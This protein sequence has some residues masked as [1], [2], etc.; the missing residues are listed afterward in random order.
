MKTAPHS[1]AQ[2]LRSHD[3]I[4]HCLAVV[5]YIDFVKIAI[6]LAAPMSI[7][8][9]R[10]KLPE[11]WKCSP[12]VEVN[13]AH[14]DIPGAMGPS[15]SGTNFY[16]LTVHEPHLYPFD[17]S[18][19]PAY[20]D[21]ING[22]LSREHS[23]VE[24]GCDFTPQKDADHFDAYK[25]KLSGFLIRM[26]SH[27]K[28]QQALGLTSTRVFCPYPIGA[29]VQNQK[30]TAWVGHHDKGYTETITDKA[31]K[32]PPDSCTSTGTH[33]RYAMH[34]SGRGGTFYMGRSSGAIKAK[35]YGVPTRIWQ[36]STE[37]RAYFKAHD[38]NAALPAD[39]HRFRAEFVAPCISPSSPA[40]DLDPI[41]VLSGASDTACV[42]AKFF[43][44][45]L[46]SHPL[47][48]AI[49]QCRVISPVSD[50]PE[51]VLLIDGK[52]TTKSKLSNQMKRRG[53]AGMAPARIGADTGWNQFITGKFTG[54]AA[55]MKCA[56]F[57]LESAAKPTTTAPTPCPAVKTD[58]ATIASEGKVQK[59]GGEIAPESVGLAASVA[60][61]APSG[62][63]GVLITAPTTS[64][65]GDGR[66]TLSEED[67]LRMLV[68]ME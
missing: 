47:L 41:K 28:H 40:F 35:V 68:E 26:V 44:L 59:V 20:L 9:V 6:K 34:P 12:H 17:V 54:M 48:S 18:L 3:F 15:S 55:K 14:K 11:C 21:A 49:K 66:C 27:F 46:P 52:E 5:P 63:S 1:A 45:V 24:F 57:T 37:L 65:Q 50:K 22:Q 58:Q 56:T 30:R 16:T 36:P 53:K 51:A 2:G 62:T 7:N 60:S 67:L 38:K 13:S 19:L 4:K 39:E 33:I 10:A 8:A 64:P 23:Q 25:S 42:M 31:G 29:E 61:Q 43:A 32:R